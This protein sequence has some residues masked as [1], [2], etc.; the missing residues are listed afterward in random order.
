MEIIKDVLKG[1]NTSNILPKI[2]ET[3]LNNINELI[4]LVSLFKQKFE[5]LKHRDL[6]RRRIEE[7]KENIFERILNRF[8]K[9]KSFIENAKV[10]LEMFGINLNLAQINPEIFGE[11][12]DKLYNL[13]N[14]I[15]TFIQEMKEKSVIDII[16]ELIKRIYKMINNEIK[17]FIIQI[18]ES[19]IISNLVQLIIDEKMQKILEL[20]EKININNEVTEKMSIIKE[21]SVFLNDLN[22][23]LYSDEDLDLEAFVG[24]VTYFYDNLKDNITVTSILGG[25]L[26]NGDTEMYSGL[27][28]IILDMYNSF[29]N[30]QNFFKKIRNNR[31]RFL[32]MKEK[33]L[34]KNIRKRRV[35]DTAS[36]LCKLD[37][38]FLNDESLTTQHENINSLILK[39]NMDYNIDIKSII[40]IVIHRNYSVNCIN[41]NEIIEQSFKFDS[42]SNLRIESPKKRFI[43]GIRIGMSPEF[44][45]PDFFY[46]LIRVKMALKSKINL[47]SLD[48]EDNVDCFCLLEDDT[49]RNSTRFSCFGY[50]DNIDKNTE[51]TLSNFTS[52][53]IDD[54]PSNLTIKNKSEDPEPNN[55]EDK[56]NKDNMDDY[57]RYFTKGSNSGL[58]GGAIAGIVIACIALVAIIAALIYF[59]RN[60]SMNKRMYDISD[61]VHK[62]Q[63]PSNKV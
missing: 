39:S 53:Y 23:I 48:T 20:L 49:D 7:Q 54:L 63:P 17:K 38:E 4:D 57:R 36:L 34:G 1:A 12:Q 55:S 21:L 10:S 16:N 47:R 13:K 61:S 22:K 26:M 44:I 40:N 33:E 19:E 27:L 52:E 62:F 58:S 32:S 56:S 6:T 5:I 45:I 42:I 24:N 50:N 2:N 35:D 37:N 15:I 51:I 60:K 18:M 46:L 14:D 3:L 43:F 9:L 30:V 28:N 29:K 25:I 11:I 8:P 59:L 31:L 41:N